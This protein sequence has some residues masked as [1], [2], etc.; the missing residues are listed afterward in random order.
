VVAEK[1]ERIY[2]WDVDGNKYMDFLAGYSSTNQGHCHPKIVQALV[3]QASK[4]T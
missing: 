4:L 2:L 1:G 3:T